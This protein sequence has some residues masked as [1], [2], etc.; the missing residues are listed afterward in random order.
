MELALKQQPP[1]TLRTAVIIPVYNEPPQ[2]SARLH[3]LANMNGVDALILSDASTSASATETLQDICSNSSVKAQLLHSGTPQRAA[4]MNAGAQRADADVLWFVHADT[5]APP[6]A[7]QQIH[8]AI[9]AG[10]RWGRFDVEFDNSR[11]VMKLV[12]WLMNSRSAL[13]GIC[14]GDQAMFVE[15]RLFESAGGFP[16]ISLM[17]DVALSKQLKRIQRP[18]RIRSRV[19]T[20]ARRW[21]ANGYLQTIVLMWLLRL[22]FALG[23]PPAALHRMYGQVRT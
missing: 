21:E 10:H 17:E 13:S 3:R 16:G 4:Q 18:A 6:D 5:T 1:Q 23:V 12:A 19:R 20:S 7:V 9:A 22:L 15:R 8:Q 2:V 14:T 11:P